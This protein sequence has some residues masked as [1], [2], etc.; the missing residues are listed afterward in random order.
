M[1][2]KPISLFTGAAIVILHIRGDASDLSAS[3]RPS[4]PYVYGSKC[5][6]E[7]TYRKIHIICSLI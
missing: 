1:D 3:V 7:K 6:M 5:S 4:I 2:G